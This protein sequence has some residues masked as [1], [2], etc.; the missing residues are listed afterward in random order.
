[1]NSKRI[2]LIHNRGYHASGPETYLI[3][4]KKLLEDNGNI[5]KIFCLDYQQNDLS[6]IS[7]F[8]PKP[9]GSQDTYSYSEQNLTFLDK[10]SILI[11]SIWDIRVFMAL[12]REL[13]CQ[14]YDFAI[15]LQYSGKL[16][17]SIFTALRLYRVPAVIRQS[18]YGLL[19]MRNTFQDAHG[20][21]CTLCVDQPFK[22]VTK[23]C[24]GSFFKTF[25][26]FFLLYINRALLPKKASC[27]MWTNK[28]AFNLAKRSRP[29]KHLKH[30]L[31]YTLGCKDNTNE[32]KITDFKFDFIYFGRLS[33]DKGVDVLLEF[34]SQHKN[35]RILLV[36]DSS[37]T[38]I[39][40][41]KQY[42]KCGNITILP[43]CDQ[44]TLKKYIRMSKFCILYS[45]W[46]DNLPNTLIEAYAC[47]K[48][49]L[50]PKIGSFI[51]FQVNEKLGFENLDELKQAHD[52]ALKMNDVE[53]LKIVEEVENKYARHFSPELHLAHYAQIVSNINFEEDKS[54]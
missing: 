41:W 16:S 5:C 3:N 33:V 42:S 28:F 50:M 6:D 8:A 27:L 7:D 14:P 30:S 17:S 12:R 20:S 39:A 52:F 34:F 22:S 24:G 49:V 40:V 32:C 29:L 43:K 21:I 1:M 31:N 18:D 23:N 25:F 11:F 44:H 47:S 48:P 26:L 4:T 36:G 2:L 53:Y 13:R 35:S 37:K 45:T 9:V 46:F 19:C 38:N 54:R 51:E 15:V 10:I